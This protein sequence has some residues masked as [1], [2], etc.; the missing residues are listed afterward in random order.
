MIDWNTYSDL[1]ENF[2]ALPHSIELEEVEAGYGALPLCQGSTVHY[3]GDEI[4]LRFLDIKAD[5]LHV[6]NSLH[7]TQ[8]RERN[9]N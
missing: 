2:G 7:A 3:G 1:Y 8:A 5:R 6:G 9:R 4:R